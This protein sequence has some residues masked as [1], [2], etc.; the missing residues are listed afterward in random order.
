MMA[1]FSFVFDVL[2]SFIIMLNGAGYWM[3]LSLFV[4]GCL[5]EFLTPET[6]AK[7]SLGTTRITG[8]LW[9]TLVGMLI[10]ICSCGSIPLGIGLYRSG[11]YLGPTLTFMT[12]SP[13]INPI[14][15]VLC[16]GLLGP[17]IATVYLITGFVAPMIIGI[18]ANKF[19]GDE[20]YFKR[21][22][23]EQPQGRILLEMEK[24]S[25]IS[26]LLSGL[27]WAFTELA[28]MIGK[29]TVTGMLFASLIFS[30]IP[31]TAIQRYL[32]DPGFISLLGI[33]VIAAIMY[34][35]AIG[36]IPFIA[37]IVASGA[38]PGVAITFL[39]AGAAT[40]ISELISI[41]KMIGKRAA[42]MYFALVVSISNVVGYITNRIFPDFV[43]VLNYD[44]AT[45]SVSTANA[46]IIEMPMWFKYICSGVLI[47]YALWAGYM[48]LQ[49][50]Y[51][52]KKLQKAQA[53]PRS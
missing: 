38:A 11:A 18:V 13:M 36:H 29:Y 41:S 21:E 5:H 9:A 50:R 2:E 37:A 1:F 53:Q 20:L 47:A 22:E 26:R 10:P 23:T 31:Q 51:M 28:M 8:V 24:P 34:V 19:A 35:C 15:V 48:E 3:L 16:Y 25:V 43:P 52:E 12:S 7:S 14:A 45:H 49:K 32:G 46:F 6:L 27:R 39:M 44:A 30:L 33:T 4:A 17:K 40:N 42:W